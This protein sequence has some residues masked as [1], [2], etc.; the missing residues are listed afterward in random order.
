MGSILGRDPVPIQ[1]CYKSIQQ[2][3]YNL[4][5]KPTNKPTNGL[6]WKHYVDSWSLS[7][8]IDSVDW[9]NVQNFVFLLNIILAVQTLFQRFVLSGCFCFN[10]WS[11]LTVIKAIF[12]IWLISPWLDWPL[13]APVSW[14]KRDIYKSAWVP[15][16]VHYITSAMLQG[17][18][19]VYSMY[20]CHALFDL[21]LSASWTTLK[22]YF[23]CD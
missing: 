9:G 22:E 2:F 11:R 8:R 6:E 18:V 21:W 7:Q 1:V 4:V 19:M 5:Y 17:T 12:L 13:C 10:P 23:P 14:R 15:C 3:L 20:T 16:D